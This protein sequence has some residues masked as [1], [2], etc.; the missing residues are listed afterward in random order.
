MK[1]IDHKEAVCLVAE[2]D[3][4]KRP[5]SITLMFTSHRMKIRLTS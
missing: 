3:K 4:R 5:T 1:T 2:G